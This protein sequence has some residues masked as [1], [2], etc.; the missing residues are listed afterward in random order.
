MAHSLQLIGQHHLTSHSQACVRTHPPCMQ[1]PIFA[2]G[3]IS[4]VC[5]TPCSSFTVT[6]QRR[7]NGL[8]APIRQRY[9]FHTHAPPSSIKAA[10]N[11][12]DSSRRKHD[13]IYRR[14]AFKWTHQRTIAPP[15]IDIY[16]TSMSCLQPSDF[17]MD[18][19]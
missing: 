2:C 15:L 12:D 7:V 10:E 9:V 1:R 11:S 8:H 4:G 18:F 17:Y 6:R 19:K 3:Q 14:R 16:L 13:F 5:L